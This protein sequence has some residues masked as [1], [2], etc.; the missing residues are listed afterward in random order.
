LSK[1]SFW[2]VLGLIFEFAPAATVNSTTVGGS[3][4]RLIAQ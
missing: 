2:F 3:E 1:K 4:L